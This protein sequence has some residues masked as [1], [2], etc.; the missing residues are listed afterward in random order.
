[1]NKEKLLSI[2]KPILFNTPEEAEAA[3][4]KYNAD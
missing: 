1:M 4:E 2:S 3:L